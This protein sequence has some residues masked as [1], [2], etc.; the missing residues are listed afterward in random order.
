MLESDALDKALAAPATVIFYTDL[1]G[2][3]LGGMLFAEDMVDLGIHW[4]WAYQPMAALFKSK[5]LDDSAMDKT[6]IP[7]KFEKAYPIARSSRSS[8][9]CTL[10]PTPFVLTTSAYAVLR[11]SPFHIPLSA[12]ILTVLFVRTHS[13][14]RAR[15]RAARSQ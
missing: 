5:A 1:Y 3:T 12:P 6:P 8:R 11:T 14:R 2:M 7:G 15:S 10:H 4:A 9:H 13:A